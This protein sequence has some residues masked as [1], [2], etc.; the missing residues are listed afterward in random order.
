[1]S[2]YR[3]GTLLALLFALGWVLAVGVSLFIWM[4]QLAGVAPLFY[5]DGREYLRF[6]AANQLSWAIFHVGATGGLLA[7]LPLISHLTQLKKDDANHTAVQTL[8][9]LGGLSALTASLIDQFATPVLARW[10]H[11][12]IDV[13]F[14]LWETIEPFRDDGLKT[15]SFLLLGLWAVWLA[16]VWLQPTTPPYAPK[17]GRFT[18]LVGGA[19]LLLGFIELALPLPWRNIWGETGAGGLVLVLLPLWGFA[20]AY[21]LWHEELKTGSGEN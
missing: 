6:V 16:G 19:L 8:G 13:A 14:H 12:N 7:L 5:E 15:L 10:Q 4:P 9:L 2:Y 11:G 18:Q 3:F 21:W 1:M 20:L 17:L